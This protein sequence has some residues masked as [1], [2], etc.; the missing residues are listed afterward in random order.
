MD[1]V[2]RKDSLNFYPFYLGVVVFPTD[3]T[4]CN[5]RCVPAQSGAREQWVCGM[6]GGAKSANQR[7][8]PP[9]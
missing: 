2:T 9:G 5:Q 1:E 3:L 6:V 7:K 4:V 8:V